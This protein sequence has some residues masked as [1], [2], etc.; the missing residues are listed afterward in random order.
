M[1]NI[2]SGIGTGTGRVTGF[3]LVPPEHGVTMRRGDA[4]HVHEGGALL[5]SN[6]FK[7]S[8]F[9]FQF[10]FQLSSHHVSSSPHCPD[11]SPEA[12]RGGRIQGVP[13]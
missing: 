11:R 8:G 3:G 12:L 6:F 7:Y 4:G 13:R 9:Q 2:S 5:I 10:Q 1:A